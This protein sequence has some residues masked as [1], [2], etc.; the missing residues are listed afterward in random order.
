MPPAPLSVRQYG[1]I[2]SA[3]VVVF[4]WTM[5]RLRPKLE[6]DP[7]REDRF[8]RYLF[9]CA[10]NGPAQRGLQSL[11]GD[12]PRDIQ[13]SIDSFRAAVQR[14]HASPF[15]WCDLGEAYMAS[16]DL[17]KARYCFARG[18]QLAPNSPVIRLRVAN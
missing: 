18:L 16:G 9:I 6:H 10:D 7:Q 3:L 8:C 11:G 17:T 12:G 5:L 2:A 4:S 13:N 1:L 15:R 14:D